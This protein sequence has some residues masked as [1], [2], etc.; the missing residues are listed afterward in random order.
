MRRIEIDFHNGRTRRNR[1]V[2]WLLLAIGLLIGIGLV[3]QH[4]KLQVEQQRIKMSLAQQDERQQKL[5]S[6]ADARGL[7][8]QLQGAVVVIEQLSFPWDKLFHALESSMSEDVALLSVM[9]DVKGAT[10]T[11]NVEA[12][13][14]S[15]MQDYIR[16]LGEDKFFSDVHLVSHQIQSA[17]PQRPVRFVLLCTWASSEAK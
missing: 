3:N 6:N 11:L 2:G 12:R 1:A 9:P 8:P 4:N 5:S 7:E 13:D 17:D 14:W 15:A 16:R 10:I